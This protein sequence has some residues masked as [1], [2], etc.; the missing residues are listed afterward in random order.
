MAK[1]A[2]SRKVSTSH[3][4]HTAEIPRLKR[5]I[6]QLE[7]VKRMIEEKRYCIDIINQLRA[8]NAGI[9]ALELEILK[10]HLESC[11]RASAKTDNPS[12]FNSKL[13]ELLNTI[14]T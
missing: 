7:G 6:G 10:G 1:K 12:D 13:S 2:T 3:P 4:D 5:L 14:K 11:I 8:S 9:K